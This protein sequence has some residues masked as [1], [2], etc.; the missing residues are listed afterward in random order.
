MVKSKWKLSFDDSIAKVARFVLRYVS[1]V[2][3]S[4][5]VVEDNQK[6]CC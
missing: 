2:Q 5:K 1:G 3:W 4:G 6:G